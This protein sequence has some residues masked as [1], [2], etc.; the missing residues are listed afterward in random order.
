MDKSLSINKPIYKYKPISYY[1]NMKIKKSDSE[2]EEEEEFDYI[3]DENKLNKLKALKEK[4]EKTIKENNKTNIQDIK[5]D[6]L[7]INSL[8]DINENNI[9]KNDYKDE[10]NQNIKKSKSVFSLNNNIFKLDSKDENKKEKETKIKNKISKRKKKKVTKK[11][12]NNKIDIVNNINEIINENKSV[13][14]VKQFPE[15]DFTNK[16]KYITKIQSM[17]LCFKSKR[18]IKRYKCIENIFDIIKKRKTDYIKNFFV[19]IKKI[20]TEP[21]GFVS[22]DNNKLK[23]LLKKE[24]HYDKLKMKYE[25]LLKELNELKN[26]SIVKQNF[27]MINNKNQNIR[28]NI[29]PTKEKNLKKD[30]IHIVKEKN[31]IDTKTIFNMCN[32][33]HSLKSFYNLNLKYY[34]YKFLF[35]MKSINPFK[36]KEN[37]KNNNY[38]NFFIINKIKS[39]SLFKSNYLMNNIVNKFKDNLIISNQISNFIIPKSY[40]FE[41]IKKF[42]NLNIHKQ[43][44]IEFNH[45]NIIKNIF[46][47]DKNEIV[48]KKEKN[49]NNIKKKDS[50]SIINE[51]N[52]K[53]INDETTIEDHIINY[54]K[55]HNNIFERSKKLFNLK[56]NYFNEKELYINKIVRMKINKSKRKANII[57]KS[58]ENNFTFYKTLKR[59]HNNI[60]TK[61]QDKLIIRASKIKSNDFIITKI[62]KNFMIK[63]ID[64]SE[65]TI[66]VYLFISKTYELSI[67]ANKRNDKSYNFQIIQVIND[68]TIDNYNGNNKNNNFI[69]ESNKLVIN[70]IIKNMKFINI[71]RN[72]F[73]INKLSSNNIS[74]IKNKNLN[75]NK[76]NIII[77]IQNTFYIKGTT[78][79]KNKNLIISKAN[80]N[81]NI[82]NCKEISNNIYRR[83]NLVITKTVDEYFMK[84]K[85]KKKSKKKKSKSFKPKLLFF[86]NDNQLFIKRTKIKDKNIIQIYN[87]N[88]ANNQK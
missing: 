57:C 85:K 64:Y 34:Y 49:R 27:N 52:L 37:S 78:Q 23:E 45:F 4:S 19:C 87:E 42:E 44:R 16:I 38:K 14:K 7:K 26:K 80:F 75:L 18:E 15:I 43:N 24:K 39:F 13:E 76:K 36:I 71:K 17:W 81:Y 63:G 46:I 22:V 60:I 30:I 84:N 12:K 33:F 73:V 41:K 25:A 72:E 21:K 31:N 29:F 65:D 53:I 32:M 62:I 55:N 70:K 83:D 5:K 51:G 79:F 28:I 35:Y 20:K 56:M 8:K 3:I 59:L 74:I 67:N 82:K 48:I 50:Y 77:K 54:L 61:T 86:S 88:N 66:D 11:S 40:E 68:F 10:N 1:S 2:E 58:K 69:F 6:K 47:S 9:N